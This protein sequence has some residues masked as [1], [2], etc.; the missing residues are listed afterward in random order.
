MKILHF[1]TPFKSNWNEGEN[2]GR[3]GEWTVV[4]KREPSKGGL[5]ISAHRARVS[6]H[7]QERESRRPDFPAVPF[8]GLLKGSTPFGSF[9]YPADWGE[10]CRKGLYWKNR[11]P[12]RLGAPAQT[13]S[14]GRFC[15]SRNSS[16][17][18]LLR[19]LLGET[20]HHPLLPLLELR[21]GWESKG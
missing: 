9:W 4:R 18:M 19:P 5:L 13:D 21:R 6:E 7:K 20:S 14:T 16:H 10:L 11:T 1:S 12:R 17:V 8:P 15:C 2:L 3:A